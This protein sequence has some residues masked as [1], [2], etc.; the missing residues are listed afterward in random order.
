M[1]SVRARITVESK[2]EAIV[3]GIFEDSRWLFAGNPPPFLLSDHR[4]NA[5]CLWASSPW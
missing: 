3:S 4:E 1:A 2:Q 5:E